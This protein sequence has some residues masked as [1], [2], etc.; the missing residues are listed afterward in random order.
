M[1]FCSLHHSTHGTLVEVLEG[2]W[3]QLPAPMYG[4]VNP[5]FTK[6]LGFATEHGR[7]STTILEEVH[8]WFVVHHAPR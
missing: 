7:K 3:Q 4:M 2:R 1:V 6:N 8:T 5:E